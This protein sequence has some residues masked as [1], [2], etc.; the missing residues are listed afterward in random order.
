MNSRFVRIIYSGRKDGGGDEHKKQFPIQLAPSTLPSMRCLV[1][2]LFLFFLPTSGLGSM[3]RN[4]SCEIF[5]ESRYGWWEPRCQ[6]WLYFTARPTEA[7]SCL[8]FDTLLLFP[9]LKRLH[10]FKQQVQQLGQSNDPRILPERNWQ[11][12]WLFF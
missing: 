3:Q 7:Q 9:S 4:T 12:V 5:L 11:T 1:R 2:I 8:L 6:A 10:Q